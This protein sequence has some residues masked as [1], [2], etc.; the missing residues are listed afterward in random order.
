MLRAEESNLLATTP[1]TV[2]FGLLTL[3]IGMQLVS[4]ITVFEGVSAFYVFLDDCLSGDPYFRW[5]LPNFERGLSWVSGIV[6]ANAVIFGIV[7]L[8][9]ARTL[10]LPSMQ[11]FRRF[12][13]GFMIWI[14]IWFVMVGMPVDFQYVDVPVVESGPLARAPWTPRKQILDPEWPHGRPAVCQDVADIRVRLAVAIEKKFTKSEL[15]GKVVRKLSGNL[16]RS[17]LPCDKVVRLFWVWLLCTW[18]LRMYCMWVAGFFYKVVLRG[19]DG[20]LMFGS[21]EDLRKP[22][23]ETT[24][25]SRMLRDRIRNAFEEIDEDGDGRL[26]LEEVLHYLERTSLLYRRLSEKP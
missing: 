17:I 14:V 10:H 6:G 13:A 1:T 22:Y 16:L 24:S 9:S 21:L 18:I 26:S 23:A 15:M 8:R 2:L 25:A 19:G 12:Q 20:V 3:R 4:A 7:G 11:L 5:G